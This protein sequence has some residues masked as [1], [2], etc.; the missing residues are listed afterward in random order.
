ML[1]RTPLEPTRAPTQRTRKTKRGNPPVAD[2]SCERIVRKACL[3]NRGKKFVKLFT[4][5]LLAGQI[6][7]AL[8]PQPD[9]RF[10]AAGR[11]WRV[12]THSLCELKILSRSLPMPIP[13]AKSNSISFRSEG[14]KKVGHPERS[15]GPR[16]TR[17]TRLIQSFF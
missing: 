14:V 3:P 5:C 11:C 16:T 10:F 12:R 1:R 13:S 2:F 6:E 9:S 15:E 8:M 7:L 17:I 4:K